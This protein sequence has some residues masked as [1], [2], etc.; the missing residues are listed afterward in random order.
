MWHLFA[1]KATPK[2]AKAR[3]EQTFARTKTLPVVNESWR[4]KKL[5]NIG[6]SWRVTV[7]QGQVVSIRFDIFEIESSVYITNECLSFLVVS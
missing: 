3:V 1:H 4:H 7:D 5:Y 2:V 6:H